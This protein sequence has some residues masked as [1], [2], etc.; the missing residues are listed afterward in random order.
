MKTFEEAAQ[1][2]GNKT[3]EEFIANMKSEWENLREEK[4]FKK[5]IR[6]CFDAIIL[7]MIKKDGSPSIAI[8]N[9]LV[10][11]AQIFLLIG[12]EMEKE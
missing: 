8:T 2:L 4:E 9:G 1:L 11:I 12:M 6:I 5:I 7:D 10:M 3:P